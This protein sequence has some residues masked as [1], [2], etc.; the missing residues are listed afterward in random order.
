MCRMMID[1]HLFAYL[2]IAVAVV[3]AFLWLKPK[4]SGADLHATLKRNQKG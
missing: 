2:A 3:G 4:K 1:L